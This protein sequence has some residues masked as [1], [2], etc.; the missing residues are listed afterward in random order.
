MASDFKINAACQ[1]AACDAIVDRLDIGAG[2]NAALKIRTGAPPA[3]PAAGDTG[4]L[5]ATLPMSATAFGNANTSGVA[6]AN[7]ITS[8][9]AVASGAAGHFRCH[10]QDDVVIF[11]GTAGETADATDMTFNDKDIVSGGNVSC[12]SMTVTVPQS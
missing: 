7:S 5:L 12:T 2:T 6:T 3:T 1:Q 9:T 11:Q 10:D 4:T 8:A